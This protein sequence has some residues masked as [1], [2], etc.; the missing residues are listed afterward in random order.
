MQNFF[1]SLNK[2]AGVVLCDLVADC[3]KS[4][5]IIPVYFNMNGASII[6]TANRKVMQKDN[7]SQRFKSAT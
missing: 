7:F 2:N 6:N 4:C 5:A 1:L 3:G